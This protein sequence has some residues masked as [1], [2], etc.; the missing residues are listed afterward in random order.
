MKGRRKSTLGGDLRLPPHDDIPISELYLHVNPALPD[1]I[2]A[3]QLVIW[4]LNRQLEELP[5][6]EESDEGMLIIR[7]FVF[8][9]TSNLVRES[10][11]ILIQSLVR[12]DINL[13]WYH[14]PVHNSYE[15]C[16]QQF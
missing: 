6:S 3:R 1:P 16:L 9:L 10:I 14:K 12:K 15:L 8:Y 4:I 13:S 11:E 5:S 2:R 7:L